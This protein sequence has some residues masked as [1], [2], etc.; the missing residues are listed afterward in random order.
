MKKMLA[1]LLSLLLM[2]G[3]AAALAEAAPIG[4]ALAVCPLN[5]PPL[6][7]EIHTTWQLYAAEPAPALDMTAVSDPET[8]CFVVTLN[9]L[10]AWGVADHCMG[11]WVYDA[12]AEAWKTSD[13]D[14]QPENGAVL[15]VDA[16]Y[17]YM[18][19]FPGWG[20][21]AADDTFAYRLE[22]YSD[23][24]NNPD[25][26]L[27]YASED[28]A[29]AFSLSGGGYSMTSYG[30]SSISYCV[31]DP[32]GVLSLGTYMTENDEETFVT[33]AVIPDETEGGE[34]YVLYYINVQTAD[35][36]NWLWT[37]DGWEDIEGNEVPAPE[38]INADELPFAL[39]EE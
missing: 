2:L 16:E 26:Y 21:T 1:V 33:Y 37:N 22:D 39:I 5:L 24:P 13:A 6:P 11:G 34:G 25:Y 4:D 8:N 7:E 15:M 17:Y 19:G 32:E 30:E 35:G 3:S 10:D 36:G 9:G 18:N 27:Q 14:I 29:M 23:D 38:G 12:E 31:Y 28:A 20:F